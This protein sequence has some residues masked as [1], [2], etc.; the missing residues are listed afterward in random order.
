MT[1]LPTLVSGADLVAALER[2]TA[3]VKEEVQKDPELTYEVA[4]GGLNLAPSLAV[5]LTFD[6]KTMKP[7]TT[8]ICSEKRASEGVD[9]GSRN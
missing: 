5:V 3:I 2:I 8:K 1:K 6:R 7:K 9:E 4:A